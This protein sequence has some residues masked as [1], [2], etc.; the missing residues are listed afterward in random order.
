[1]I[2]LTDSAVRHLQT[3]IAEKGDAGKGLRLFVEKEAVLE[4]STA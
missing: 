3:L 4:C 2:T 1:M